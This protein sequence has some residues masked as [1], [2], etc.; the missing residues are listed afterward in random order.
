M[1]E[2]NFISAKDILG[3]YFPPIEKACCKTCLGSATLLVANADAS[4]P[5]THENIKER[6]DIFC[7]ACKKPIKRLS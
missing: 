2:K 7:H 5:I 3:V 1:P 4:E 6:Q